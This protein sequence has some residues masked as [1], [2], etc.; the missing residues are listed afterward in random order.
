MHPIALSNL[1]S[2]RALAD[3]YGKL[4]V[5]DGSRIIENAWYIQ[6][7][8]SGMSP[9]PIRK[10]VRDLAKAAHVL[11]IDAGQD[12]KCPTGGCLVTDSPNLYE[13]LINE[14]VVY[15]GLHTYGGMSGRLMELVARGFDEMC[16]EDE[17]QW[18]MQ[19]TERFNHRLRSA[20]LPIESGCDGAYIRAD[21]F[22]VHIFRAFR[23]HGGWTAS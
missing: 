1:R 15:E 20:G 13:K 10:I 14:V 23:K 4:V 21:E 8:E 16:T 9:R 7:N 22:C 5:L 11:Q 19:Q 2:T 17:V 3:K 12:A 18:V 6:R